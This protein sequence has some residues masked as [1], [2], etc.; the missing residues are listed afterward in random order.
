ASA[1]HM[2]TIAVAGPPVTDA[3]EAM[4]WRTFKEGNFAIMKPA[5]FPQNS[6]LS[7]AARLA[8]SLART[9]PVSVMIFTLNEEVNLPFCLRSLERIDDVIVVDS[10]SDDRTLQIAGEHGARVF[11]HEFTGFG[12]QRNWAM[13]HCD[14]KYEW[15]LI[16]DADERVTPEL[17]EEVAESLANAGPEL[18]AF[19]L[20]RKLHMWGKWLKHSSLYPN[21][22]V[23][24]VRSGRVRYINRGHAETQEVEGSIGELQHA[25]IDENHK[26]MEE[27]LRRQATYAAR[28]AEFEASHQAG[29]SLGELVSRDPMLRRKALKRLSWRLP[30]RGLVYFAYAFVIRRGFLDGREGY[31]FCRMKAL[32]QN[33]I[34]AH[35]FELRKL[36]ARK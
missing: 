36:A 30:A 21:W 2:P 28:E 18:A 32:Y 8:A 3:T 1:R 15:V 14:P 35:K 22:V 4:T 27:W 7:S 24:L 17:A 6:P 20:R 19:R 33:M 5:V 34:V 9:I 25:L 26:G 10:Y 29:I 11:Q 12:D 23:R 13:A 16:L 31:E